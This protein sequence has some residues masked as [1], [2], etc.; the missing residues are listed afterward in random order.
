MI[1]YRCQL[2]WR[3][4][5]WPLGA[6]ISLVML[7]LVVSLLFF[8]ERLEKKWSFFMS[9]DSAL[10]RAPR[11]LVLHAFGVFAFLYLPIAVLIIYSFNGERRR[12]SAWHNPTLDWVSH[13][14]CRQCDLGFDRQAAWRLHLPQWSSR[15]S[16][17]FRQHWRWTELTFRQSAVSRTGTATVNSAGIITGLSALLMLFSI[18][19]TKLSLLTIVLGHGTALI[20][21]AT[22]EVFVNWQAGSGAR[23]SVSRSPVRTTGRRS[24]E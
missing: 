6:A 14:V 12:V 16:S 1:L 11:W 10:V 2:V 3:T 17:A 18:T 9:G 5:G 7:V 19:G 15:W 21:V 8:S 22:T 20:S 4:A 23:R 13:S 24:G